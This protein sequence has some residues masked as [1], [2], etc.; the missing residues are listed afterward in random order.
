M[1][2]SASTNATAPVPIATTRLLTVC[3]FGP[4][5][6]FTSSL[7]LYRRLGTFAEHGVNNGAEVVADSPIPL[8]AAR[9][10]RACGA[11]PPTPALRALPGKLP[12][13]RSL[14]QALNIPY[15]VLQ[16]ARGDH[17]PR[18]RQTGPES[19]ALHP[20]LPRP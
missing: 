16:V 5:L 20:R 9:A 14:P 18:R 2:P 7:C 15:R 1:L 13:G 3:I 12:P 8:A 11:V 19:F 6:D 17:C 4:I 10:R